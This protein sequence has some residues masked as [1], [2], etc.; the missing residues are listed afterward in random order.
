MIS[1]KQWLVLVLLLVTFSVNGA[2]LLWDPY[3]G[4]HRLS[5]FR[6]YQG[7]APRVY[8]QAFDVNKDNCYFLLN[9]L[10]PGTNY[11]FAVTAVDVRG[12]E[13]DF[14]LE[15]MYKPGTNYV[16]PG[17]LNVL[18]VTTSI[19]EAD[20]LEYNEFGWINWYVLPGSIN[21]WTI[22]TNQH[23][24]SPKLEYAKYKDAGDNKL[25]LALNMYT[26]VGF[27]TN[28]TNVLKSPVL[29]LPMSDKR[30]YRTRVDASFLNVTN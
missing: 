16:T 7:R 13:S 12:L 14:S 21:T 9:N 27:T 20:G 19:V 17:S 15:V 29:Y 30:F 26:K 22:D 23:F 6:V 24:L 2:A 28:M 1:M 11:Y 4:W 8:D 25:Y 5:K 18:R 3:T 10:L